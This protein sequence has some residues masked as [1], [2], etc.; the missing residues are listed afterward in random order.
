MKTKAI[1]FP[2][3]ASILAATF[4]VAPPGAQ[5]QEKGAKTILKAMSDYVGSQKTI[6]LAF[7]SDNVCA[8]GTLSANIRKEE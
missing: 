2:F 6:Q 8:E 3:L 7:D 5:A 4:A 1:L